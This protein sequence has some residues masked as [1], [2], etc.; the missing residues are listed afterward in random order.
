MER[1]TGLERLRGL[2]ENS[3]LVGQAESAASINSIGISIGP[4]N[5]CEQAQRNLLVRQWVNLLP[6][7]VRR[8]NP[9]LF[10]HLDH[11][12][13]SVP[14][15]GQSTSLVAAAALESRLCFEVKRLQRLI[16]A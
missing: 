7:H 5:L 9:T 15:I 12:C 3:E 2:L 8:H 1:Q 6:H 11:G 16:G 13:P 14:S 10:V 4:G